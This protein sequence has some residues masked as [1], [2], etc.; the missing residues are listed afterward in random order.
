MFL[1]GLSAVLFIMDERAHNASDSQE[2]FELVYEELR[3]LAKSWW[4]L[5]SPGQTLQPTALVHEAYMKIAKGNPKLNDLEHFR[6]LAAQAMRQALI[7][8]FRA[9]HADKRGGKARSSVTLTGIESDGQID[10]VMVLQL[11]EV[12]TELEGFDERRARIT[13]MRY[14]AGMQDAEIARV[15]GVSERTIRSDW[16]ATRAWLSMRMGE[17]D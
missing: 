2:M 11:D 16:R 12:L 6:A 15:L 10:P 13:E 1:I 14:F 8:H 9:K 3:M 17:D 4:Q 5:Q 7:Q